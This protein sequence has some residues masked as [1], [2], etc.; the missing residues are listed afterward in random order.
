MIGVGDYNNDLEMLAEAD[1]AAVPENGHP[2][3]VQLA[4]TVLPSNDDDAIAA[5]IERIP[6]MKRP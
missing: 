5:L 6:G 1:L 4:D 3:A 2:D